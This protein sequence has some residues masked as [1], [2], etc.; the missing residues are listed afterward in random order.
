MVTMLKLFSKIVAFLDRYQNSIVHLMVSLLLVVGLGYSLYLG[1]VLI[2]PDAKQ[3]YAIAQNIAAG[4]GITL[5]GVRPSSLLP[6]AVSCFWALLIK[7]GASITVLRYFN[8]IA[9]ALCLYVIRSILTT[10]GTKAGAPL[11]AILIVGYPVLFYTAGTLYTQTLFMF[12][13]LL[14]IR[15][16]VS[17]RFTYLHAIL[18]GVLSALLILTHSTGVFIPPLV[19]LWLVFPRNYSMI[20]K[21]IVAAF[22]AVICFTPWWYR[23]YVV[24][25]RFIPLTSHGGDTL[26]MGN[27]PTTDLTA[28]YKYVEED[29]HAEANKLSQEDLNAFYLR[30]TWEF[31]SQHTGDAVQL[32]GEKLL[33]HFKFRN[34]L[35][36][37]QEN[38]FLKD[39]ILFVTY[40]PLLLC[41]IGRLLFTF[42]VPLSRTEK[43]LVAIYIVSAFFHALFLPRLRFRLPYDAVLIAHI[44]IMFSLA[45]ERFL[46]AEE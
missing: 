23:N 24:F 34:N 11:A 43:L 26:Y 44:G 3:Y 18:L 38:S 17:V 13:M 7:L 45:K 2:F 30:K 25:D 40:Y 41:L 22:V 19:V 27:N 9:L 21:G 32:Y 42:Y 28:W 33:Y 37:S 12:L 5:D 39:V 1:N 29:F 36:T 15:V 8:F 20:G 6:P 4:N 10:T 35:H 31:W 14:I 16:V 46:L